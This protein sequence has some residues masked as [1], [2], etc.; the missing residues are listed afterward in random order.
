MNTKKPL[1]SI[2]LP[3]FKSEKFLEE[4]LWSLSAQNYPNIEII[5]MVDYLGDDSLRILKK[6]KKLDKRLRIYHN[7]QRYGLPVTLNRLAKRAKG[8]YI[9]FMDPH[10]M[11]LKSRI[12]KQVKFLME[13]P[14]VAAVGT[15]TNEIDEYGKVVGKSGFPKTHEEIYGHLISG[16]SMKFES[17]LIDKTRLPKDILRFKKGAHHPFVYAD[18]FVKIGQFGMIA[19]LNNKLVITRQI[20]KKQLVN[21]SKKVTFIKILFES[22][23]N[24]DYK[25]S[26]RSLFTPLIKQV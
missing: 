1:V 17:A 7:V 26:L 5:A 12:S 9:A 18:V 3:V 8:Q 23:M 16:I 10:G 21:I 2:L 25:P 19:N 22:T 20:Q 6:H 15:Q 11:S 13:N 4:C 14:K 24:L